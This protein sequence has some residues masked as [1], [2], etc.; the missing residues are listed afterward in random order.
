M[1]DIRNAIEHPSIISPYTRRKPVNGG[2]SWRIIG[3][4]V[5][6]DRTVGVGVEAF[7]DKRRRVCL[8]TV[9]DMDKEQES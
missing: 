3:K 5:D 9:I 6:A 1:A 7:Y 4:N 8:C 2:T